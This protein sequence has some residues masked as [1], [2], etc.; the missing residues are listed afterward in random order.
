MASVTA[1]AVAVRVMAVVVVMVEM[2]MG[3]VMD[4]GA[5]VS[6]VVASEAAVAAVT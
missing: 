3:M 4:S 6:V 1:R 2:E 5:V